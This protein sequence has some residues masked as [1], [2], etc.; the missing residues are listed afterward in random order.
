MKNTE[1]SFTEI[2]GDKLGMLKVEEPYKAALIL[3]KTLKDKVSNEL[4]WPIFAVAPTRDFVYLFSKHSSLVNK[5]GQ[6]VIR[7]FNN[8]GYPISTDVWEL[9]D[10]EQKVIGTYA[11]K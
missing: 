4:G 10:N 7:E 1:V 8:S 3:T 2:K 5:V 11:T 9:N 6:V